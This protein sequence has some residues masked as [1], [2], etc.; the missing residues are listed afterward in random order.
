MPDTTMADRFTEL[1]CADDDWVRAE[2]AEIVAAN[3]AGFAPVPPVPGRDPGRQPVRMV[4]KP[5][6]KR[7]IVARTCE[8]RQR[9]PPLSLVDNKFS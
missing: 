4:R 9:S 2:F 1:V 7:L 3:F 8:R 5:L 6:A